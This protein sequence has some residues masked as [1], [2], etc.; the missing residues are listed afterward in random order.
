MPSFFLPATSFGLMAAAVLNLNN[1]RD[2]VQDME[3]GKRT[4]AVRAG[5]RGGTLYH[6]AILILAM[7]LSLV[8]TLLYYETAWQFLYLLS[9]PFFILDLRNVVRT[10]DHGMLDPELKRVAMGALVY[11]VSFGGG[12]LLG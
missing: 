6:I 9:F 1:L 3:N 10:E 4:L 7:L 11:A 2:R 8:H 12:L 5:K